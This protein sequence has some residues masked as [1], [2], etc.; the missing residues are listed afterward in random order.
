MPPARSYR[1]ANSGAND[2][3]QRM[4]ASG[5]VPPIQI[6]RVPE[7]CNDAALPLT[8]QVVIIGPDHMVTVRLMTTKAETEVLNFGILRYSCRRTT[9]N[10]QGVYKEI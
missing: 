4:R 9:V 8:C 5:H 10:P 6:S 1:R 7:C 3:I 2:G